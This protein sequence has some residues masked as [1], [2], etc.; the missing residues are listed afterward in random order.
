MS[1]CAGTKEVCKGFLGVST[2]VLEDGRK[3]A[4]KKEIGYDLITCHNRIRSILK[5]GGAYIYADDLSKDMLALYVSEEDT[6]PVGVFLTEQSKTVTLVEVTS[7]STYGKE[8]ISKLLFDTL[9]KELK[10]KTMKGQADVN[11]TKEVNQ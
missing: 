2:K 3:D 10:P 7:P 9:T 11:Q 4:L 6:T 1:G 5:E 8:K